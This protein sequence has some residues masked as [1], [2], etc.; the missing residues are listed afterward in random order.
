MKKVYPIGLSALILLSGGCSSFM[1]GRFGNLGSRFA[2]LRNHEDTSFA[3]VE[4]VER[5]T[6]RVQQLPPS[7]VVVDECPENSEMVSVTEQPAGPVHVERAEG[8]R[9]MPEA[10]KPD[11]V[12]A[13]PSPAPPPAPVRA[14]SA[15]HA[16]S[17]APALISGDL[18]AEASEEHMTGKMPEG[19]AAAKAEGESSRLQYL[20]NRRMRLDYEVRGAGPS[21]IAAVDLWYTRDGR[22]WTRADSLTQQPPYLIDF[23]EEGRFGITLVARN[24]LGVGQAAPGE[25]DKPQAW[26]EIDLTKPEVAMSEVKFDPNTRVMSISWSASDR[27]L[28]P[29]SVCLSYATD[30]EGPWSPIARN[31]DN[32]GHFDWKVDMEEGQRFYVRVEVMDLAGN[33]GSARTQEPLVVDLAK[34]AAMITKLEEAP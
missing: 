8:D 25:G 21:G 17:K 9:L 26:V 10:A 6:T 30:P 20:R 13:Q 2:C 31:I 27:N 22:Q 24:G 32:L 18:T 5:P 33:V 3:V 4:H 1:G 12:V 23:G 29:R 34:P 28:D 19:P 15:S 7:S 16:D 14:A 11:V